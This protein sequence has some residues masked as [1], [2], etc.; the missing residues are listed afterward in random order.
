L[1]KHPEKESVLV[2]LTY[3]LKKHPT[4]LATNL[5]EIIKTPLEKLKQ[6]TKKKTR[7]IEFDK[8]FTII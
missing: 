1:K 4:M 8:L 7:K 2:G 6:A 3:I 5:P